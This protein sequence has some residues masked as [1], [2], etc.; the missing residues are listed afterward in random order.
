[1]AEQ[2]NDSSAAL[3]KRRKQTAI[4][5]RLAM[6]GFMAMRSGFTRKHIGSVFEELLIAMT[7]RVNDEFGAPPLT[8]SDIAK[9]LGLP[10]SNVRHRLRE[11]TANGIIRREGEYGYRGELDWLAARIDA[12]YFLTFKQAIITAA[13]ELR[14]IDN[15]GR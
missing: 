1:M 12:D 7:I 8:A 10:R 5:G 9:H 6:A 14:A 15:E 3:E 4:V 2:I 13:D 11:L